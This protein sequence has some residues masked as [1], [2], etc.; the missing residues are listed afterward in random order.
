VKP[1]EQHCKDTYAIL[2][3]LLGLTNSTI[4][5]ITDLKETSENAEVRKE[6]WKK[7]SD[8]T[9]M[10]EI[11]KEMGLNPGVVSSEFEYF[12]KFVDRDPYPLQKDMQ[13]IT[14]TDRL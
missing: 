13:W 6:L 5:I 8:K 1:G 14:G 10:I 12:L 3:P 9:P 7:F 4:I 2:L 11:I